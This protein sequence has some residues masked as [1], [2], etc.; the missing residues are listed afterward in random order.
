MDIQ[1]RKILHFK[2]CADTFETQVNKIIG[3]ENVGLSC[4]IL[5]CCLIDTLSYYLIDK[6]KNNE[7]YKIFINQFLSKANPKYLDSKTT[8][9]LHYSVRCCLVHAY[10]IPRGIILAENIPNKHLSQDVHNNLLLDLKSF[11][12]EVLVAKKHVYRDLDT[13][14]KSRKIFL[15]RYADKP[16][17]EVYK[18][19]EIL[20]SNNFATTGIVDLPKKS[21]QAINYGRRKNYK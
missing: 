16:P 11:Y 18:S 15:K 1:D 2:D 4:F 12:Q 9:N 17:F 7:R 19:I 21:Y 8:E 14:V 13:S 20:D 10:T 3:L 5:I 6:E